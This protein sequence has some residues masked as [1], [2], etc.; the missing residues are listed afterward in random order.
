VLVTPAISTADRVLRA[1]ADLLTTQTPAAVSRWAE[2]MYMP[3][4]M[5]Q[6][7][8]TIGRVVTGRRTRAAAGSRR[9]NLNLACNSSN[10]RVVPDSNV[11]RIS[12]VRWGDSGVEEDFA[13]AAA[14]G[15]KLSACLPRERQQ[16]EAQPHRSGRE[17]STLLATARCRRVTLEK[18]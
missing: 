16:T 12:V 13:V 5:A 2:T 17:R 1:V 7:I 10:T 18:Y 14:V 11:R 8:D 6:Y 9:T 4:K 3:A 15:D